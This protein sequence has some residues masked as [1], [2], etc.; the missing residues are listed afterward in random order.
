[1]TSTNLTTLADSKDLLQRKVAEH[2]HSDYIDYRT[3]VLTEGDI[4]D[5]RKLFELQAKIIGAE[6]DKKADPHANL[7]VFNFI[8]HR[9]TVQATLQEPEAPLTIQAPRKRKKR[10]KQAV[11]IED[12]QPLELLPVTTAG[13][14]AEAVDELL[15]NLDDLFA[16]GN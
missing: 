8:I 12:V 9:G 13:N 11:D 14:S 3:S 4:D 5:K 6:A 7:P 2:I 1:M 16:G 10:T 15:S